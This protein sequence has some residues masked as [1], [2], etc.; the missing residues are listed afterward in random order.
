MPVPNPLRIVPTT[1]LMAA[2]RKAALLARMVEQSKGKRGHG[3]RVLVGK[4]ACRNHP[5]AESPHDSVPP[6]LSFS[7]QE[8]RVQLDEAS[9]AVARWG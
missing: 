9:K 2:A 1:D 5:T 4:R 6:I 3:V 7:V 8:P